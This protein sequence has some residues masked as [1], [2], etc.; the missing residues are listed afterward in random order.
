MPSGPEVGA[1]IFAAAGLYLA[2]G[3]L[4]ATWPLL[5]HV[6]SPA[7]IT[8][9]GVSAI[10]TASALLLV[11]RAGRGGLMLAFVADLWGTVLIIVLCAASGGARSP[12]AIL[13]LFAIGHAA[14][15]QPRPRLGLAMLAVLLGFLAP[16]AYESVP[17]AFGAV[18]C[19]G[20][21]LSALTAGFV[22]FALDSIRR[23]RRRLKLVLS[24]TAS[25]N[26]SL[27]PTE[28][29][30]DF[31]R[32]VIPEL[33][34]VCVVD[35]LDQ[36]GL[37]VETVAAAPQQATAA[38]LERVAKASPL[39]LFGAHPIAETLRSGEPCVSGDLAQAPELARF[40]RSEE[41]RRLM[42]EIGYRAVAVFPMIARGRT[43]GAISF[44]H[45]NEGEYFGTD[46]MAVLAD[47]SQRVAMAF[48]NAHLYAERSRAASTLRRSLMPALLPSIPGLE[49]ASYFRP[50]GAGSE[51]G[52]D[53]YDVFGS[54]DSC[55]LIVGDV[56]GKGAEAATLT[57]FL[58]ATTVAYAREASSPATVLYRVNQ[59][60]LER[61][62][63]GRFATAILAHL[64]ARETGVEVAIA[65]AGH[66]AALLARSEGEVREFGDRGTLLGVFED[67]VIDEATT[68]LEPGDAL[69]LYTDGL[70]EAHAPEDVITADD[71][72]ERLQRLQPHGAEDTVATLL[73]LVD[74]ES[75]VRDDIAILSVRVRV[76]GTAVAGAERAAASTRAAR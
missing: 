48:D 13:Y 60:M 20:V 50:M 40:A 42:G 43:R 39:P 76:A 53:F 45:V 64:R 26:A 37:I 38:E 46:D 73:G 16:L 18:I 2:G 49:L 31:A 6:D 57:G 66:P 33:A 1:A 63:D 71:A 7:A 21:V 54:P 67:P 32:A 28:T 19:I 41:H 51:V 68:T 47:M 74:L 23:Q 44:V 36:E 55:W 30:R 3:A 10:V 56:C 8:S 24:A 9:V 58:R 5:P 15:F 34:D 27:D 65:S 61:G 75:D 59:V 70:L 22:H 17:A 35:L 25:L 11:A 4:T 72:I 52:G 29:V 69:S 14:A 62:F 12:F